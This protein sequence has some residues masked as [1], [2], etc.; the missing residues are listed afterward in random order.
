MAL[1]IGCQTKCVDLALTSGASNNYENMMSVISNSS[2]CVFKCMCESM[3]DG[4]VLAG[5][6]RAWCNCAVCVN[7]ASAGGVLNAPSAFRLLPSWAAA[8]EIELWD[9]FWGSA[10]VNT[11][12]PFLGPYGTDHHVE[13]SVTPVITGP[14]V[15]IYPHPAPPPPSKKIHSNLSTVLVSWQTCF[16]ISNWNPSLP[17]LAGGVYEDRF[18]IYKDHRE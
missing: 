9:T 14:W 15:H 13:S 7:G 4:G 11:D 10:R 16:Q 12:W 1:F 17:A 5:C 8:L 18:L 6:C 2:R 3:H